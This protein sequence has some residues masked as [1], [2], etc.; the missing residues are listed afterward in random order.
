MGVCLRGCSKYL[1][2]YFWLNLAEH[3]KDESAW[4]QVKMVVRPRNQKTQ[5]YQRVKPPSGGFLHLGFL[6]PGSI[7]EAI[8]RNPQREIG[9]VTLP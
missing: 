2:K 1:S 3:G 8:D 4:W 9:G 6:K 5:R 7:S